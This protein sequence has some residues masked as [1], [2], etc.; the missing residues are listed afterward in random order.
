[1]THE[2]KLDLIIAEIV[3]ARKRT[4][5]GYP[6]KLFVTK[7]SKLAKKISPQEIHEF[8]LKL[9]DDEKVLQIDEIPT[10]IKS[11]LEVF[12]DQWE[13]FSIHILDSFDDWYE[14]YLMKKTTELSNLDYMS[15]LSVY[16]VVLDIHEKIQMNHSTIVQIRLLPRAAY[17]RVLFP[18]DSVITRD[19][20]CET[21]WNS[22]IYLLKKGVIEDLGKSSTY[23]LWDTIV[24]V[25]LKLSTFEEFYEK[26]KAEYSGRTKSQHKKDEKQNAKDSHIDNKNTEPRVIFN[27]ER[28]ELSIEGK[29]IRF[30]KDSFRA[31]LLE[32]LLKD[33]KSRKKEW[34]WDEVIEA[35]EDSKDE[36]MSLK[37]KERFYP[38]CDGLSKH[39]ALKT[40]INDLLIFNRS[41][42]QINPKYL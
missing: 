3:E 10:I 39:I 11:K 38:A 5:V 1:M 42:V 19:N 36:E 13:Y 28:V 30:K 4:R 26:I 14:N 37:H 17:F 33:E 32:I 6:V 15:L 29:K 7:E 12:L 31:R 24:T 35:I 21:R 25:I 27:S 34:S 8:L 18:I 41:T 20:Y 22:L 9:Q 2:E 16:D 23:D 40:G